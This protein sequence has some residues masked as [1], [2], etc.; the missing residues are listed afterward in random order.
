MKLNPRLVAKMLTHSYA[1]DVT[2]GATPDYLIGNSTSLVTDPE[3]KE[4]NP[5]FLG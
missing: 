2:L 3:F 5:G 4:L 1:E